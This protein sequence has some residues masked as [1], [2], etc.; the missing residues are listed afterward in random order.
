MTMTF[1]LNAHLKIFAIR[2]LHSDYHK[3]HATF[4]K[5]NKSIESRSELSW[6]AR[7]LGSGS[8]IVK[9]NTNGA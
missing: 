1:E 7:F 5:K 2:K 3:D 6:L 8:L 4:F 9:L